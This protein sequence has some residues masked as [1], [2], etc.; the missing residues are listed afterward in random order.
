MYYI[1][2]PLFK[3]EAEKFITELHNFNII[4]LLVQ[5]EPIETRY[6]YINQFLDLYT[7]KN[8]EYLDL[9]LIGTDNLVNM[10]RMIIAEKNLDSIYD[11]LIQIQQQ[12]SQAEYITYVNAY[13]YLRLI[14]SKDP[15]KIRACLE[16][17]ID[18]TTNYELPVY[19]KNEVHDTLAWAYYRN[20]Y[21]QDAIRILEEIV[22]DTS[23]SIYIIHLSTCYNELGEFEKA[24]RLCEKH[25]KFEPHNID[26]LNQ[27]GDL[28]F[29]NNQFD[30]ANLYWSELL[31][32]DPSRND[33]KKKL[34]MI[35]IDE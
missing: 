26:L 14:S 6:E 21:Y 22:H 31:R 5:S 4:R 28:F 34:K 16:T 19:L 25:L 11:L 2:H 18:L 30:K 24:V 17:M 7:H 10:N 23:E 9:M 32:I 35:I 33:I 13:V 3:R 20:G 29:N 15:D 12:L 1:A 8:N 27:L